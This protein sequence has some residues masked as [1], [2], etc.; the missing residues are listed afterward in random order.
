MQKPFSSRVCHTT[1]YVVLLALSSTLIACGGSGGDDTTTG[2][3][4]GGSITDTDGDG[5]ADAF[6]PFIDLDGD[7]FDDD[8]GLTQ[9][10]AEGTGGVATSDC[11][12]ESGTIAFGE[13]VSW[14]SNCVIR[15]SVDSDGNLVDSFADSLYSVGVQRIVFC[16][17]FGTAQND[18]YTNFADGE[19]GPLSEAAVQ[20]FQ[21]SSP[22]SITDDGIVGPQTWAKLQDALT[23]L[24][25]AILNETTGVAS[26]IVHGFDEGR[27]EG[28]PLFYQNVTF[29][30]LNSEF[31]QGG[32]RL[33]QNFPNTEE[34]LAFSIA[35]PFG[36]LD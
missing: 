35:E 12:P 24:E 31:V 7:G 8:T 22:N 33:A 20:Q 36:L 14:N 18:D 23:V 9:A 3:D 4:G 2:A 25:P 15:R 28:I 29:D 13:A 17:G 5:I 6:D 26:P 1:K 16:S 11:D 30:E 34:S 27:C 10:E 32:W 21:A 19:Y